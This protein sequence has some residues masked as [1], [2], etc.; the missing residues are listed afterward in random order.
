M[1]CIVS[2]GIPKHSSMQEHAS[3]FTVNERG[4][5]IVSF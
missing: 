3:P 5:L 1:D 2:S 4:A